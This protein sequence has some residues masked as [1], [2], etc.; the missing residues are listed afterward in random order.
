MTICARG[1]TAASYA[2][3]RHVLFGSTALR[4]Q[5]LAYHRA[6]DKDNGLANRN[7]RSPPNAALFTHNG[8]FP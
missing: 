8:R 2:A 6:D 3:V 7:V 5:A 1:V 4:Q